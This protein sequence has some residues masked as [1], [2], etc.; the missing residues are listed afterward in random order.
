MDY[1][2]PDDPSHFTPVSRRY[3]WVIMVRSLI[4]AIPICIGSYVLDAKLTEDGVIANGV[5]LGPLLFLAA[6]FVLVRPFRIW[7]SIG[8][9][10]GQDQIQIQRGNV[11]RVDT[12][13]PFSRVQHIDI[14]EGPLERLF[15]LAS[16]V[17]H[18]AGT[19]NSV[20]SLPG[21][22]RSDAQD[23]RDH[24]RAEIREDSA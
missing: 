16:L 21:L 1:E 12:I 3:G 2:T 24:I 20:V 5:I 8:Y 14:A 23:L 4:L 18:S 17:M 15:G 19:H 9:R 13:M 22:S 6:L 11:W 7:S 10:L